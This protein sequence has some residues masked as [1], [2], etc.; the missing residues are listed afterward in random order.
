[1]EEL[2]QLIAANLAA[3]RK[4][5]HLTQAELAEKI[6]YSDKVVSK[7]ERGESTPDVLILHQLAEIYGVTVDRFL[8]TDEQAAA[9]AQSAPA[10]EPAPEAPA[11]EQPAPEQPAPRRHRM[12]HNQR[13][14]VVL[15]VILVWFIAM[16]GFVI[17][18]GV[19]E[20]H[21]Y[22]WYAFMCAVPVSLV[23]WLV[24]NS[25]WGIV[26]N[27]LYIISLLIWSVLLTVFFG[28]WERRLWL[29]FL[30]GIP[31][32]L[33]AVL[34]FGFRLP[35]KKPKGETVEPAQPEQEKPEQAQ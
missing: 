14:I 5:N 16:L 1:M 15:S 7:W 17:C 35:A 34:S 2:K 19:T 3:F 18:W 30:L 32:Q 27:N 9:Q 13:I 8:M 33:A 20:P 6:N 21:V 29:I 28:L 12:D 31:A 10:E 11:A 4:A 26:R 22:Y 23:V 24:L 25:I